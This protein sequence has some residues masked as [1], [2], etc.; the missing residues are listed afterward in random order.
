MCKRLIFSPDYYEAIQRPGAALVTEGI[1][2]IDPSGIRTVDGELHELDLIVFATG[3][4]SDAF[5]RPM[6]IL[7]REGVNL[8]DFWQQRP[9]AYLAISMPDF[10]NFFML[11]RPQWPGGQFFID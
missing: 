1:Q 10:P 11:K 3:Y 4:Q 2:C 9:Q 5:M 8:E 7:G 6:E